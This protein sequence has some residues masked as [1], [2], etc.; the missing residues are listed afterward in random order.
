MAVLL[1]SGL[2]SNGES[3]LLH[4]K[5]RF[6]RG[7]SHKSSCNGNLT[8]RMGSDKWNFRYLKLLKTPQFSKV[9]GPRFSN[10]F[11][12]ETTKTPSS[13]GL[14][15]IIAEVKKKLDFQEVPSFDSWKKW[16]YVNGAAILLALAL[17][18]VPT[19]DAVDALKTCTCL[20]KEC[21]LELAKCIA[22]P[23]CAA[24]VACLQTCNN[25]PDE[26]ECQIKCGDLFANS[27]VDEFNDCAVSRKKCVPRKSDVGEFPAPDPALL[28][29]K[30]NINDFTGKWF[31]TSGLNPTFDTFDCQLHDFHTESNRLVGNLSWRIKTPD[32]G[33]FTRTAV[34]K[35]VQDPKYPGILYNHDNPF[36]NYQ[37]DWYILSSKI[38]NQPDDYIF[39]YYRGRN[40]AW[41]GY[42]GSVIYTRSAVLP[43][44]IIPE[45]QLAA[46]KVGRDF[47]TFT[48]TN[49]TCGPEP[50]LVERL[51]KTV[52]EGEEILVKEVEEIELE[53]EKVKNTEISLF[54][55]LAEGFQELIKDK[56]YFL[57]ELSKEEMDILSELK[58]E[59]KE[60][61]QLFGRAIP[62]RKLR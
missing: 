19:A 56:D 35:F 55:K 62:L 53:V 30:F 5:S 2:L 58:M 49:N 45:L 1:Y 20:L 32:T 11:S 8:V 28:V 22:N 36:L 10:I 57:E 61:E 51:E 40:D 15:T 39:V 6:S 33:F 13:D 24:N 59:A 29:P 41:D 42:G 27:V 38:E 44:S 47:S 43:E 12:S 52:E 26:T 16:S 14:N 7:E 17:M 21:R 54:Q 34:Q 18:F 25:R 3:I 9:F 23:S 50:P 4:C 60:V 37:D 46:K 31:I 48:R